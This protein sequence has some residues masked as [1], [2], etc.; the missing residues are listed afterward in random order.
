MALCFD[1][2]AVRDALPERH[3]LILGVSGL[4]LA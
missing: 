3:C 1:F 2:I 4:P